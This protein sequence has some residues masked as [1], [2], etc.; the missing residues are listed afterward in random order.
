MERSLG[1]RES[2]KKVKGRKTA[3][4][5]TDGEDNRIY[6]PWP[7]AVAFRKAF[8]NVR[9]VK[10]PFNFF[11]LDADPELGG[12][13]L[14]R[15]AEETGGQ[16]YFPKTIE[17]VVSPY[18]QISRE[19]GISYTLGYLSD[20]PARGGKYRKIQVVVAG[21]EYRVSQSRSGY[22]Q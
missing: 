15:I 17:E 3:L 20:K 12:A 21:K 18:D 4:I 7:D 10:A 6:D 9:R 19:L 5:F 8:N 16:A 14:K 13:H 22:P 2:W 1:Q 11:G